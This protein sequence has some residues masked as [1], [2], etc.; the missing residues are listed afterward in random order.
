M[1][2]HV[3]VVSDENYR[4]CVRHGV[5]AIPG[6][7][8]A[9]SA[10]QL[11]SRIAMIRPDDKILF[12]ITKKKKIRGVF[13]AV[14]RAFFDESPL[15]GP[16]DGELYP[17]RIRIDNSDHV[18][19]TPLDLSD[20]Y[21]LRDSG[22]IWTFS[23][24]RPSGYGNSIFSISEVEFDEI[25]LL[26]L[27]ANQ[28]LQPPP[29]IREPYRHV[30]PNVLERL[31]RDSSGG[32]KYEATLASLFLDG[33]S[34]G[35]YTE[36]VGPYSDYLAYV[37]TSFQKEIDVVLLHAHPSRRSVVVAYTIIELKRGPFKEDGL[38]QL[39]RYE[40]WFLKK[41]VGGDSRAVRT[42]A[43][44]RSFA[45]DV[46]DYLTRRERIEGKRV[47]LLRYQAM[48]DN[49]ELQPPAA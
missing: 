36:I 35:L 47:N 19:E 44:A 5:A 15:W 12:Y 46:V 8:K 32:P 2:V 43:V 23:L 34:R 38:A 40:D 13:R 49:L 22:K 25:M 29:H 11:I 33:L 48:G 10:D 14:D 24:K 17:Y 26:F 4:T 6:G 37:P 21:D 3:F 7:T 30:E 9:D 31:H 41:R 16:A 45:D 42:V 27:K 20:I 18:F 39:L 28:V 1:A